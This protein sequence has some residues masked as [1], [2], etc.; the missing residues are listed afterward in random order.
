MGLPA[1]M[2]IPEVNRIVTLKTMHF[3]PQDVL[4]AMEVNLKDGLDTDKIE[5]VIDR[6]EQQVKHA[7]PYVSLS[8]IFI[9]L[10][11]DS[12]PIDSKKTKGPKK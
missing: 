9:E 2:Q 12:C 11:Q 1:M 7:L 8:K 5:G 6:I 4:V 3:A 10:K